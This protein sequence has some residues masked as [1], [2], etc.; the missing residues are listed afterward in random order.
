[1]KKTQLVLIESP[2]APARAPWR[3]D[4]TTRAIGREGLREAREALRAARRREADVAA[5]TAA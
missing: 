3:I 5:N 4:E 2:E 1:M